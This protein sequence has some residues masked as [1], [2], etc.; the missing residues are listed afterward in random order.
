LAKKKT[1]REMTTWW[2]QRGGLNLRRKRH[3]RKN[4]RR[5]DRKRTKLRLFPPLLS[6]THSK[7]LHPTRRAPTHR[8]NMKA[9]RQNRVVRDR[10]RMIG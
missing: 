10:Y 5:R 3:G 8:K 6:W 7:F 4:R 9:D 1:G 2:P